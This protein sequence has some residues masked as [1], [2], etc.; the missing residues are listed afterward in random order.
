MEPVGRSAAPRAVL[1]DAYGT[2]FD[3]YSVG[4]AAEQLL[5]GARRAPR[6]ALARQAD[7]VHA[8]DL[9]E[10]PVRAAFASCTRAGLR[11]A[12]LRARPAARRGGEA[13]ADATQYERPRAFPENRAGAER[14]EAARRARRHPQQRRPR[15]A[16]SRRSATPASHGLLDPVLSVAGHAPLQDRSR[17]PTRSAPRALGLPADE[18]LFVSSNGWDAIGATWFGY[19]TLWVNRFGLPLDELGATPH[20]HRHDARATSSTSSFSTPIEP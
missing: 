3:V 17:R 6:A 14:A 11:F 10:R 16:R 9:D 7:R 15:D 20:A 12:A 8:A 19:T 13:R 18:I 5:P 4:V 1:F 2:L